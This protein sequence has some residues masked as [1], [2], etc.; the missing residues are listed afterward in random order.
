MQVKLLLFF[1]FSYLL[2]EFVTY[3]LFCLKHEIVVIVGFRIIN[4]LIS[5]LILSLLAITAL[6]HLV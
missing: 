1:S 5:Y 4:R 6:M 3:I 2:V